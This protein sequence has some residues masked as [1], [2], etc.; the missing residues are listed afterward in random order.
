MFIRWRS[1]ECIETS[2]VKI[3]PSRSFFTVLTLMLGSF[4]NIA[5]PFLGYDVVFFVELK[6][7]V[8]AAHSRAQIASGLLCV[9]LC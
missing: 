8:R 2:A 7:T 6:T 3:R 4:M 5:T 9:F 1:K